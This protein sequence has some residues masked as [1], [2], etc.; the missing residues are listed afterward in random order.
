MRSLVILHAVYPRRC[1]IKRLVTYDYFLSHSG[2]AE[3]GPESL[4]AESPFRSGEILVRR[5][6][7]QRGLTLIVAKG[8]AIQQFGSF[9]VEYQ[10]ASFAGAFLDYFESEYARKAKKIASWINQRFGQ[11][12]DTDLERFVSDNLGKWG[13]EFADNPYESSGGSE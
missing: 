6:I 13:V 8:L 12:S 2:D 3:G 4:H 9:G 1:D 10:A 11:M 7:V 5:E